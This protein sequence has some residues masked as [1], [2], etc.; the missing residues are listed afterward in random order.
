MG[1]YENDLPA[2]RSQIQHVGSAYLVRDFQAFQSVSRPI[3]FTIPSPLTIMDTNADCFYQARNH[4]AEDLVKTVNF[5]ILELVKA[6]CKYVQV[7]EPLFARQVVDAKSFGFEMPERCFHRV[8]EEVCKI[9]HICCS[10]SNFLDEADY[11]KADPNS[12]H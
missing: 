12:Y 1:A 9:V 8:P 11:K 7:D 10:Y 2:I 5:E 4:L 3:K 6:G